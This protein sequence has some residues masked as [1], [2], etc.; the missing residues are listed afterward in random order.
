MTNL[1]FEEILKMM[2]KVANEHLLK[3]GIDFAASELWDGSR[4]YVYRYANKLLS[5]HDQL[6]FIKE[7]VRTYPIIYLEDPFNEDD[8][9]SFSVL[10]HEIQ[11]RMVVG[12]DLYST[13]LKRFKDGLDFKATNAVIIKPNQVGTITDTI[14]VIK[15]A[16]KNKVITVVSHRS[17][18]T[19]DTL[20]C[21]LAVGLGC[22]YIKLGISGERATKINE[23]IRIEERLSGS[24]L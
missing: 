24:K 2:T 20:I 10:T 21:H 4:Y 13:N 17:G 8:F 7:L 22:D 1:S 15:E 14:D 16:K 23:I 19:E 5:V 6:R 9:V 18:E 11:P 3:L 12:D